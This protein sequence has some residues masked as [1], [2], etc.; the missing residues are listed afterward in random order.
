MTRWAAICEAVAESKPLR[1]GEGAKI[2]AV[3]EALLNGR[4]IA[5]AAQGLREV[6][7]RDI[8]P[9]DPAGRAY[10]YRIAEKLE[11]LEVE[12]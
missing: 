5:E 3:V 1:P 7:D 6:A 10:Y 12:T 9:D 8:L 11:A 4:T 2:I